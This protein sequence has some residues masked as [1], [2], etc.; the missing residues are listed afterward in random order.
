MEGGEPPLYRPR[1]A[2]AGRD[3]LGWQHEHARDYFFYEFFGGPESSP[4]VQHRFCS[5]L[6]HVDAYLQDLTLG[7]SPHKVRQ[8]DVST[9]VYR[10]LESA[11]VLDA[12]RST[13]Q[14]PAIALETRRV[15]SRQRGERYSG[16]D[17]LFPATGP[18]AAAHRIS[19]INSRIVAGPACVQ[20][21]RAAHADSRYR[22]TLEWPT[23]KLALFLEIGF[24][25]G[26]WLVDDNDSCVMLFGR[27][28][29]RYRIHLAQRDVPA[30]V[31]QVIP[32]RA[33]TWS[34]EFWRDDVLG[35]PP[36][37]AATFFLDMQYTLNFPQPYA[38][39][40]SSDLCTNS[41]RQVE[42]IRATR[43]WNG[44]RLEW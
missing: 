27:T 31:R 11:I 40:Y 18:F 29:H 19:D 2:P 14:L 24:R 26:D 22:S 28:G 23:R 21:A 6:G 15:D 33:V 36:A 12:G 41:P 5:F 8:D 25:G 13:V 42:P 32:P 3:D 4:S 34:L 35:F 9:H 43:S 20:M 30:H 39:P 44:L 16:E 7:V 1:F 17:V 38:S 37:Q 10:R